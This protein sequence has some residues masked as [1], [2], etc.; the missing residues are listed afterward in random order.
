VLAELPRVI[1]GGSM[2]TP[3]FSRMHRWALAS[4]RHPHS[5]SFTLSDQ[6]IGV[7]GD[8]WGERSRVEQAYLSGVGLASA[9]LERLTVS[10]GVSPQR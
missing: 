6:L 8:A 1:G 10:S 9:L 7:C 2:P 3:T 5:E 4:P